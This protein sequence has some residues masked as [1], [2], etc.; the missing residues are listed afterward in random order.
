M[1]L[2]GLHTVGLGHPHALRAMISDPLARPSRGVCWT[3]RG[4]NTPRK[5]KGA[6][7]RWSGG[8]WGGEGGECRGGKVCLGSRPRGRG[9]GWDRPG[10]GKVGPVPVRQLEKN[11]RARTAGEC[12]SPQAAPIRHIPPFTSYSPRPIMIATRRVSR[13]LPESIESNGRCCSVLFELRLEDAVKL[14]S[15]SRRVNRDLASLIP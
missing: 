11:L 3:M 1:I 15:Q 9:L 6:W 10:P 8:C 2:A 13:V 4:C 14:P 7:E 12:V 5:G